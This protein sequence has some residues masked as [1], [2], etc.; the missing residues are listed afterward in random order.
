MSKIVRK[1]VICVISISCE[2]NEKRGKIEVALLGSM[3]DVVTLYLFLSSSVADKM[4]ELD[5]AGDKE[6]ALEMLAGYLVSDDVKK[7]LKGN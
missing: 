7:I 5:E 6:H 3:D 2:K 4:V 1:G